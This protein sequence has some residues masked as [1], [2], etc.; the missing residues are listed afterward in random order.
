MSARA[1]FMGTVAADPEIRP[2]GV[3]GSVAVLQLRW[4]ANRPLRRVV[5]VGELAGLV[6]SLQPGDVVVVEGQRRVRGS[7]ESVAAVDVQVVPNCSTVGACYDDTPR[8]SDET[9]SVAAASWQS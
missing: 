7:A 5:A 2:H 3:H 1:V 9:R 6:A 8:A 4:V